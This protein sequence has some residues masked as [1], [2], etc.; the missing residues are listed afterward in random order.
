MFIIIYLIEDD[1]LIV[2]VVKIG[3]R[4]DIYKKLS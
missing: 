1:I 4:K 2:Y 3:T